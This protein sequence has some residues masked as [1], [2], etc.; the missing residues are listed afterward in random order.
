MLSVARMS[1]LRTRTGCRR[2]RRIVLAAAL[3]PLALLATAC[4]DVSPAPDGP[5]SRTVQAV[6]AERPGLVEFAYRYYDDP[7]IARTAYASPNWNGGCSATMIGPNILLTAAHCGPAEADANQVGT[8]TFATYRNDQTNM[9]SETFSCRRLI[10]GWPRHDLA[11]FFCDPSG[12]VNPGDKYGYLDVETRAPSVG[13]AVY[14][15]WQN[16]VDG[17]GITHM[18]PLYSAGHVVST[19][20][21][22]WSGILGGPA[23][24]PVGI[25]MDTW[26]V[27]GASGSSNI[28]ASTHRILV[29]PTSTA[30]KDEGPARF[31]FS[32]QTYEN[33][34]LLAPGLYLY[35]GPLQNVTASNFPPG[36][37]DFASYVGKVDKNNNAVFD[38]QEDIERQRGENTRAAY[39][40]G[41]ENR[42]RNALWEI[43]AVTLDYDSAQTPVSYGGPGLVL[44]HRFLNL[45]PNTDYR[46]G[47]RVKTIASGTPAP[48]DPRHIAMT[49]GFEREDQAA[50]STAT[51]TTVPGTDVL[52]AGVLHTDSSPSPFFA[53]RTTASFT[54]SIS[55][56]QLIEDG[57]LDTFELIDQREGWVTSFGQPGSFLPRG[58]TASGPKPD[59]ALQV[60]SL[61]GGAIP[62]S[63]QKLLFLPGRSQDLCFKAAMTAGTGTGTVKITSGAST[64]L[65]A[66]FPLTTAWT[67]QCFRRIVT[68]S[69]DTT[70]TF[71]GTI[72][73]SYL[74]DDVSLVVDPLSPPPPTGIG[75]SISSAFY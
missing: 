22:I 66:A 56:I 37:F 7:R 59:F 3:A 65:D 63:T 60:V 42:R 6:A 13:D 67:R 18:T 38:V 52:Q 8:A 57:T 47:I 24:T 51:L 48:R 62:V 40:L 30:N 71:A 15:I 35:A 50:W 55:E 10:H 69:T 32:M 25:K 4:G 41:F 46:V 43:K 53:I 17:A 2:S 16:P 28:D 31:A 68:P 14:S 9:L 23:N 45:K 12:G 54:G 36:N 73:S 27:A 58:V 64:V 70:L 29:G 21:K 26:A 61:F 75:G 44:R 5:T 39:W 34:E 72:A 1:P 33:A 20:E 49:V 11:V 19:T 74:V